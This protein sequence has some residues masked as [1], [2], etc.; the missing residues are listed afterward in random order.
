MNSSFE[1]LKALKDAGFD[2][3]KRDAYWWPKS[4]TFET[5]VG[6]ILTQQT[7]WER[8]EMA[9]MELDKHKLLELE[10][11]AKADPQTVSLLIKVCGFYTQKSNRIINISR[12]I[13]NDFNS[14]DTFCEEVSRDWLLSQKGVGP[15]SADAI[16]CYACK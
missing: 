8:V 16:L 14:F 12:A 11:L 1:L 2:A 6:A 7:K 13:L 3:T 5:V 9:L 10:T 15:E 4:G